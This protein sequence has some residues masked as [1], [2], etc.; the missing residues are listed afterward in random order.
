MAENN[1]QCW[2]KLCIECS[3]PYKPQG[4]DFQDAKQFDEA[5][6]ISVH[7]YNAESRQIDKGLNNSENANTSCLKIIMMLFPIYLGLH[8][9]M[10]LIIM[11]QKNGVSL[12]PNATRLKE[13][14]S[15]PHAKY[16]YGKSCLLMLK[17][18]LIIYY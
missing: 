13:Q 10:L 5:L 2:L 7:I 15:V 6:D 9:L 4:N 1:K 16:F 8:S 3:L 18:I 11:L 12:L 14:S 17:L